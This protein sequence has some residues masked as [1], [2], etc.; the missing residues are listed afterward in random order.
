MLGTRI[1]L[2]EEKILREGKYKLDELYAYLDEQGPTDRGQ[3]S[4]AGG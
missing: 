4:A 1:I 2:D 3:G